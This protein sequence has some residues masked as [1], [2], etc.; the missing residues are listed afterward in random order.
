MSQ[1]AR[2]LVVDDE[3]QIRHA[4]QVNLENK[5]YVVAAVASGESGDGWHRTHSSHS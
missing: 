2:I 5:N 3:P 4:L 1:G